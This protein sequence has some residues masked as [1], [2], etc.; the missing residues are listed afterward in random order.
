MAPFSQ[1]LNRETSDFISRLW[2]R[3]QR[4]N[5]FTSKDA[6]SALIAVRQG[7]PHGSVVKSPRAMQE[8]RLRSLGWDDPFQ[9][10]TAT[11]SSILAW[12]IP[13]TTVHGVTK[14]WTRLRDSAFMHAP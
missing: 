4:K 5:I 3:N 14:S 11:H 13:W 12:R 7:L 10:E 9:K 1:S 6:V 8:P 2:G